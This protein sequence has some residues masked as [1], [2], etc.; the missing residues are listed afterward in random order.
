MI[1]DFSRPTLETLLEPSNLLLVVLAYY[2]I[3]STKE[4]TDRG[5]TYSSKGLEDT[6]AVVAFEL[7]GLKKK[8]NS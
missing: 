5:A 4:K 3:V 6:A 2:Y 7:L 8:C 1:L